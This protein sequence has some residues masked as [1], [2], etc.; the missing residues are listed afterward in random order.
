[1]VTLSLTLVSR[2][3]RFAMALRMR[4]TLATF[5]L[6]DALVSSGVWFLS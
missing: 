2:V 6:E 3:F 5:T 1:M 4:L